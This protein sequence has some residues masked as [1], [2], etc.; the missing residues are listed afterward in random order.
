MP[1][2][3]HVIGASLFAGEG[4]CIGGM[5]DTHSGCISGL[6][7]NVAVVALPCWSRDLSQE[8]LWLGQNLYGLRW[9]PESMQGLVCQATTFFFF[10]F[11]FFWS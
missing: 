3:H 11:W 7:F 10:F 2:G 1:R 8:G 5:G 6:D 9:R 4:G